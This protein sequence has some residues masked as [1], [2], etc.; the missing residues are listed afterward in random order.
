MSQWKIGVHLMDTKLAKYLLGVFGMQNK[1]SGYTEEPQPESHII[2]EG[3]LKETFR[4]IMLQPEEFTEAPKPKRKHMP[5]WEE[6]A[7]ERIERRYL[8]HIENWIHVS[9]YGNNVIKRTR[10]CDAWKRSY[11][12]DGVIITLDCGDVAFAQAW[13]L[14]ASRRRYELADWAQASTIGYR[15][16]PVRKALEYQMTKS[17]FDGQHKG[18]TIDLMEYRELLI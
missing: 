2:R 17:M 16:D 8:K 9:E 5:P 1:H 14:D 4:E 6:A 11:D 12:A 3:E 7:M 13:K 10:Y 15:S 18:K